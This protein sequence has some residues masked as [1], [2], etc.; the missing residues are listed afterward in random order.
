MGKQKRHCLSELEWHDGELLVHKESADCYPIY[1][2]RSTK[3]FLS[4]DM[5][6]F[7]ACCTLGAT[8]AEEASVGV[9]EE[10][11]DGYRLAPDTETPAKV[12]HPV[13]LRRK[14]YGKR[15]ARS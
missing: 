3:E 10:L 13:K 7:R 12:W 15:Y 5:I 11:L 6:H 1:W 9:A 8:D 2:V 4:V 14:R